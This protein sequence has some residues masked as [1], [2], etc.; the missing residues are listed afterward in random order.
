MV[1]KIF[2]FRELMKKHLISEGYKYS[3][4]YAANAMGL[5]KSKKD[6]ESYVLTTI[7]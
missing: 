7:I 6:L 3:A 1:I 4:K 2:Q 5:N